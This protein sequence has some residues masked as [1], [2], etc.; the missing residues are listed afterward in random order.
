MHC[1]TITIDNLSVHAEPKD[2]ARSD[3]TWKERTGHDCRWSN[4]TI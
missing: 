4:S 2:I 1:N 3:I